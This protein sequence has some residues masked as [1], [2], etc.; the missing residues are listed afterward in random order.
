[1]KKY[2]LIIPDGA[3]D[4]YRLF[5]RSPLAVART[6]HMDFLAREGVCGLM[7]TLYDDLPKESI[8]AQLGM[9]GWDPHR[10]YPHGR[11]SCELL[12]LEDVALNEEDLAFRANMVCMENGTLVSYSADC[13]PTHQSRPLVDLI[14]QEM[15]RNFADF[16]LY[17][18]SDFR[19]TLVVRSAGVNPLTLRC[20]EP[21]ENHG[22][23][24]DISALIEGTDASSNRLA[25]RLNRYLE[26]VARL[27]EGEAANMLF[28]WSPSVVLKLTPFRENVGF[29]APVA[30]VGCMDFLHGIA[31]AG[32]LDFFKLGNGQPET[33]YAGK[34]AKTVELLDAGYGFVICHINGP[35]EAAHMGQVQLKIESL[36]NIDEYIVGPVLKYFEQHS[37]ELG[38]VLI[39][40]DHFT[41]YVPNIE[42]KRRIDVHSADPVPFALWNGRERDAARYYS[43][44]DVL[45]GKYASPPVSHLDL[46]RLMGVAREQQ[47]YLSTSA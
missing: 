35:D 41:N 11:A 15:K 37:D 47:V 6:P 3:G 38:G 1:M 42:E 5:G 46:L 26:G 17:H 25:K 14:N 18:N 27:L 7:Q 23:E 32:K 4:S 29:E 19:N 20:P 39:A 13:I 28:P 9:L 12:A 31:K 43:E 8:V 21:H 24:F 33:D 10:H 22:R 34:G 16:E 44:D 2:V 36:E 40:P 45:I 30:I